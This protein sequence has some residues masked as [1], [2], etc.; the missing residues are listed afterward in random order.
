[1]CKGRSVFKRTK[2]LK[3]MCGMTCDGSRQLQKFNKEAMHKF[4]LC[5]KTTRC[6]IYVCRGPDTNLN[7]KEEAAD[8]DGETKCWTN[9][10]D[11]EKSKSKQQKDGEMVLSNILREVLFK[12]SVVI[13]SITNGKL[14]FDLRY[15]LQ[16]MYCAV[17]I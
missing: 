2:W 14:C 7:V 4:F 11:T 5:P 1:M 12:N 15:T 10:N 17:R 9:G 8:D 6:L 16:Y 3:A 13:E